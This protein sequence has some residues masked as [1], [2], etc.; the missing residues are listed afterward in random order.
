M[1]T[2][3]ARTDSHQSRSSPF[4]CTPAAPQGY[5]G[6]Q[7]FGVTIRNRCDLAGRALRQ[8]G[9]KDEPEITLSKGP[10]G[11]VVYPCQWC[12]PFRRLCITVS[13]V[14]RSEGGVSPSKGGVCLSQALQEWP[15]FY[16]KAIRSAIS[17]GVSPDLQPTRRHRPFLHGK[18]MCFAIGGGVPLAL[19]RATT[20]ST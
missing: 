17:G 4:G 2:L 8:G 13:G 9:L 1:L 3:V 15:F 20:V 10:R 18:V 19:F 7:D 16:T 6:P 14:S 12:I 5:A 11:C